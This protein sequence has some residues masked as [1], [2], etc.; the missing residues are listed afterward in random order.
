MLSKA[1]FL[2]FL[3]CA[4]VIGVPVSAGPLFVDPDIPNGETITYAVRVGDRSLSVV[5]KVVIKREGEKDLYQITSS[6]PT[7]D[8]TILLEKETMRVLSV[9]NVKKY[10]E[11][12]LDSELTVVDEKVNP[13]LDRVKLVDLSTLN[14]LLRGFPFDKLE[15]LSIGFYG[16]EQKSNYPFH[17]SCK[18]RESIDVNGKRIDCYKLELGMGGFWGKFFPKSNMW[19]SVEPPHYLVKYK[20]R[21]GRPG[22]PTRVV[23][24]KSYAVVK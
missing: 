5:E 21:S 12:K 13:D 7:L 22:S 24:L 4:I 2:T 3:I 8:K 19:Y 11:V 6:S 16:E 10:P 14:Y 20:G 17:V 15:K 1:M 9:H 18:K 23:E